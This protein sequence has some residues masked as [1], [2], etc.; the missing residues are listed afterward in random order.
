ML[1]AA[2]PISDPILDITV[3]PA[4]DDTENDVGEYDL[5]LRG[6]AGVASII[7]SALHCTCLPAI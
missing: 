3:G 5:V 4:H 2:H 1:L 7:K 6:N